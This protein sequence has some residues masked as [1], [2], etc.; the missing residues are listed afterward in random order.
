M[1]KNCFSLFPYTRTKPSRSASNCHNLHSSLPQL[2]HSEAK[3][4]FT[5]KTRVRV[6]KS[7]NISIFIV[8][9]WNKIY[10]LMGR[11]LSGTMEARRHS[12][13]RVRLDIGKKCDFYLKITQQSRNREIEIEWVGHCCCFSSRRL[14]ISLSLEHGRRSS[15]IK[16]GK[17]CEASE[18]AREKWKLSSQFTSLNLS[19][20]LHS[21]SFKFF[22]IKMKSRFDLFHRPSSFPLSFLCFASPLSHFEF[23][24]GSFSSAF[25]VRLWESYGHENE[26]S[27]SSLSL[28]RLTI[29]H[30]QRICRFT[31]QSEK[32]RRIR[33]QKVKKG[34]VERREKSST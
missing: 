3:K 17:I 2:R 1:A 14:N 5:I 21:H 31:S 15:E 26:F 22:L 30:F 32:I 6:S 28:S 10:V 8:K 12:E 18:W 7:I 16:M 11:F 13:T 27:P 4:S 24:A 34:K 23:G 20:Y 33:R 29:C 9:S 19:P 25:A